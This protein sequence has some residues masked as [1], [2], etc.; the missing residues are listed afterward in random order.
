MADKLMYILND[1]IQNCP[2][3]KL[4]LVVETFKHSSNQPLK[5]PKVIKPFNYKT[6][7][8]VYCNKQPNV[9]SFSDNMV[10]I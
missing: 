9:P 4:Q 5:V 2:F 3:Y 1:D 8:T 7:G 10:C 6:A